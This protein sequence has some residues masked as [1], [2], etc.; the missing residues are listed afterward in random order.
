MRTLW[1]IRWRWSICS[2]ILF[3]C[4]LIIWRS[5]TN[6]YESL[7]IYMAREWPVFYGKHPDKLQTDS[8]V[9][10]I[11]T[12]SSCQSKDLLSSVSTSIHTQTYCGLSIPPFSTQS[13]SQVVCCSY[14]SSPSFWKPCIVMPWAPAL[15]PSRA[16]SD[17]NLWQLLGLWPFPCSSCTDPLDR[18]STRRWWKIWKIRDN[19]E[20]PRKRYE[21]F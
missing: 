7:W 1:K 13:S 18:S 12:L 9:L 5:R 4:F 15:L 14:L 19:D 11:V 10:L 17:A 8:G 6:T 20:Y 21:R 2:N 3:C 16:S